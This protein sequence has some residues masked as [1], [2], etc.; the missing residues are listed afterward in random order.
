[1]LGENNQTINQSIDQSI[2]QSP[3]LDCTSDTK[4][5][6]LNDTLLIRMISN[7]MAPNARDVQGLLED[8]LDKS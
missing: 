3:A 8:P 6:S 4:I 1:M 5:E 7:P 2:N